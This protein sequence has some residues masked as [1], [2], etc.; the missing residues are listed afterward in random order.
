MLLRFFYLTCSDTSL[1]WSRKTNDR[2]ANDPMSPVPVQLSFR[3]VLLLPLARVWPP[4]DSLEGRSIFIDALVVYAAVKAW[5]RWLCFNFSPERRLSSLSRFQ[6]RLSSMAH[7]RYRL[8]CNVVAADAR[9]ICNACQ[10]H[11]IK[12]AYAGDKNRKKERFG[13]KTTLKK[14]AHGM[15]VYRRSHWCEAKDQAGERF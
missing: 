2:P 15:S 11:E 9:I 8:T 1:T 14:I 10:E 12:R 6:L 13:R 5:R 4:K 3:Q 7:D